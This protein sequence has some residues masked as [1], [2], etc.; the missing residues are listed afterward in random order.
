MSSKLEF[1]KGEKV[2]ECIFI[3]DEGYKEYAKGKKYR[4]GK[5]KCRCGND[6][7]SGLSAVFL[8]QAK[9]CGCINHKAA[10]THGHCSGGKA[11][12][13]YRAWR[14]MIR[15][16]TNPK[17]KY[18]FNYGGR[19]ITI[20]DRWLNSF[21]NFLSDAGLKT[22]PKHTLDRINNEGNYE[23]GNIRWAN[24][25]IQM[26]NTRKNVFLELNGQRK[27]VSEWAE[28]YGINDNVI[29]NRLLDNWSV[30]EAITKPVRTIPPNIVTHNGET[31]TVS[32]WAKFYNIP[33]T[34]LASRLKLNIPFE[35]AVSN[36]I[37]KKGK[38]KVEY[39]GEIYNHVSLS[40]KIGIHRN[41]IR[42]RLEEGK[43]VDEIIVEG[44]RM[45]KY[46]TYNGLT[47]SQKEWSEKIGIPF[48][49]FSW[50]LNNGWT[51]EEVI[52]TPMRKPKS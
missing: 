20:C 38:N 52:E 50:R 10:L 13:E 16:C 32:E 9:S 14:G 17:D 19:G 4:I 48:K 27:T 26:R 42:N 43:T 2:G 30:E 1:T 31:K 47:M 29:R 21:E 11:S 41:V 35:K 5:F 22:N 8:S 24:R 18:Y 3:S 15:R 28:I 23:P 7:V 51:V 36:P 46:I 12:T 33:Y 37:L 40:K 44:L 25:F 45:Q 6:F 49:L 39:Q 34:I